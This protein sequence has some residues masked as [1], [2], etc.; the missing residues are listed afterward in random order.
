MQK[1]GCRLYREDANETIR[2]DG[3]TTYAEFLS[4]V[5]AANYDFIV[6]LA[7]F[8]FQIPTS[9]VVV[10]SLNPREWTIV[11]Y[12]RKDG[13]HAD[14]HADI[15]LIIG[16]ATHFDAIVDPTSMR[17]RIPD[18]EL[19]AVTLREIQAGRGKGPLLWSHIFPGKN[20]HSARMFMHSI[21][22]LY[23][24]WE[25]E[26]PLHTS[27]LCFWMK[28]VWQTFLHS[29]STLVCFPDRVSPDG[30]EPAVEGV[31][32][33][34]RAGL[35]ERGSRQDMLLPL[36][37]RT[38]HLVVFLLRFDK[39]ITFC[40]SHSRAVIEL[41]RIVSQAL[42]HVRPRAVTYCFVEVAMGAPITGDDGLCS[43]ALMCNVLE[44]LHRFPNLPAE[45]RY[46]FI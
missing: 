9:I 22:S 42:Q 12:G 2:L 36:F 37:I 7:S 31:V 25:F 26:V 38:S 10:D 19:L 28:L 44:R 6:G 5:S 21:V 15:A 27:P 16:N 46:T 17:P 40:T 33:L 18:E 45:V 24:V 3:E 11:N 14:D 13:I 32:K 41:E 4:N 34:L 43:V 29:T 1:Y 20:V 8:V 30:F 35:A 23:P 39:V